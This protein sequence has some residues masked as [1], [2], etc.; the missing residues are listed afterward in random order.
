VLRTAALRD[1]EWVHDAL[2]GQPAS[3]DLAVALLATGWIAVTCPAVLCRTVGCMSPGR[4]ALAAAAR[5]RVQ[6]VLAAQLPEQVARDAPLVLRLL[7]QGNALDIAAP[8]PAGRG[9]L[10]PD[11]LLRLP[12]AEQLALARRALRSPR[13][14]AGW[15]VWH[16]RRALGSVL[17][18]LSATGGRQ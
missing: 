18:R 2:D 14:T 9:P 3:A 11:M 6:L 12:R 15:L 17:S 8:R 4:I 13:Y 5:R 1:L 10:A 16:G 7:H